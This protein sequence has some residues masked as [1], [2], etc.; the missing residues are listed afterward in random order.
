[1]YEKEIHDKIAAIV[2]DKINITSEADQLFVARSIANAF[3]YSY[4]I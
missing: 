4:F 3:G 1:M 2:F